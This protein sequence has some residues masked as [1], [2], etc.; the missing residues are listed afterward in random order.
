MKTILHIGMPKTGST[1]LQNCLRASAGPLAA[2]S[3]LYASSPPGCPFNNHRLL[4]L[5]FTGFDDLPRHIRKHSA[6]APGTLGPACAAFLAHLIG[7]GDPRV[8]VYLRRPSAYY[9]SALQQRLK[10]SHVVTPPRVQS[11]WAVLA[12]YAAAFGRTRSACASTTAACSRRGT[13][14]RISSRLTCPRLRS[15]SRRWP[16][17]ARPTPRSRPRR[18]T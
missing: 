3:A 2:R 9:L 18:W 12:S 10:Q 4:I 11:A 14:S 17:G 7:A 5:G 1:A 16:G 15:T 13:S 8:A 6:Y